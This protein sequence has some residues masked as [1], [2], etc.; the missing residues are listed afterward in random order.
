MDRL[1]EIR[2]EIN[3]ID[4]NILSQIESRAILTKE[5]AEIKA[6]T[7]APVFVPERET[8]ILAELTLAASD[9]VRGA[10]PTLF[11]TLM[12]LSRQN[13][14]ARIYRK[15]EESEFAAELSGATAAV[16]EIDAGKKPC[17][18]LVFRARAEIV[19]FFDV[20]DDYGFFPLEFSLKKNAAG[21]FVA[22]SVFDAIECGQ[23]REKMLIKA[24]Y[25]I[26]NEFHGVRL[27]GW[28]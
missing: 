18:E 8:E 24:M 17:L 21:E 26:C 9:E 22:R 16:S 23:N 1:V 11:K 3:K 27:V 2:K 28:I 13:Q 20:L 19:N 5:V 25:Q 12:R 10:V 6:E 7:M 15:L 14:Y 4:K